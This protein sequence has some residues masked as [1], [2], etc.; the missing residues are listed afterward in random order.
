MNILLDTCVFLWML[1]ETEHLSATAREAIEDGSNNL[2]FHQASLWEIQIK[3]QLGKLRLESPPRDLVNE[4]LKFY[5]IETAPFRD[6]AIWHLQ[7]LPDI[8]RDPFDRM[9]IAHALT[10]GLKFA[11]PDPRIHR[12]P[13]PVVW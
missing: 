1:D 10:E 13:V 4:G 3:Y 12:Y 11:T 6:E 7:K 2:F 9:L 8:H 5:K